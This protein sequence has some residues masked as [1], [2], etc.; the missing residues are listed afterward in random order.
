[1]NVK[2]SPVVEQRF[3]N[4]RRR[5]RL[6][7][8]RSPEVGLPAGL[9]LPKLGEIGLRILGL[10]PSEA[11]RIAQSTDWRSTMLVPVPG[12]VGS[13]RQV[14]VKGQKALLVTTTGNTPDGRRR[15]GTLLLW[16]DGD[17]VYA[18][19]GNLDSLDLMQ[20]ANSIP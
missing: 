16:S 13:F 11:R 9:D 4:D 17:M 3:R 20:M 18:L 10:D 15:E 1:V 7:Q 19:A 6:L 12:D 14:D 5:A 8:A 2:M